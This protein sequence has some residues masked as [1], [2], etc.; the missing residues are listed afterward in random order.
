MKKFH[1]YLIFFFLS[2]ST[3]SFAQYVNYEVKVILDSVESV[4]GTLQKVTADGIAV[5]DFSGK[6][7]IFKTKNIVKIKVRRKG[8]NFIESFAGGTGAGLAAG[9]AIFFSGDKGY[10]N[11]R[12]NLAG[13]VFLT[14]VGAMLGSVTGLIAEAINTKLIVSLYG[15]T[16]KFKKEHLKL[17]KYSKA[18]YL[19]KPAITKN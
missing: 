7:Y 1:I 8:L 4:K 11:F 9:I 10:D 18:Y 15:N 13:T 3:S 2:F 12:D 17:E 19:E 6:Y 14:G 16:E 5:E